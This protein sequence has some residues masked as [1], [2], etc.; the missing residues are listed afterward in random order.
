MQQAVKLAQDGFTDGEEPDYHADVIA[1][2][3]EIAQLSEGKWPQSL[4]QSCQLSRL[5]GR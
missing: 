5:D 3:W 2:A 1:V 4:V